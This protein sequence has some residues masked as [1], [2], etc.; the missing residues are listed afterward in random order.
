[1]VDQ[2]AIQSYCSAI[3]RQFRPARIVLFGSHAYGKP[4]PDSDV[5]LLVVSPRV[6]RNGERLS[7]QIRHAIPRSFPLD[8]LVRTPKEVAHRL[9]LGDT[10]MHEVMEKGK[11]MYD[12]ADA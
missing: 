7:V 6:R 12:S 11:L 8:L 5:D 1:M 2:R 3:A 9:R 10:F 4:T